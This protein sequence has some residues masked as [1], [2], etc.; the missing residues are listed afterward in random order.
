MLALDLVAAHPHALL[1]PAPLHQVVQPGDGEADES[2]HADQPHRGL[3][4]GADGRG[5]R[6]RA[7]GHDPLPGGTQD[8]PGDRPEHG[9]L[10]QRLGQAPRG[11][12]AEHPLDALAHV[13]VLELGLEPLGGDL[14]PALRGPAG[15]GHPRGG[16]Q[17]RRGGAGRPGRG[18]PEHL[19]RAVGLG[20]GDHLRQSRHQRLEGAAQPVD[21]HRGEEA[22]RE[23]R[24]P[25]GDVGRAGHLP[26]LHRLLAPLRGGLL[27]LLGLVLGH[28]SHPQ[29]GAGGAEALDDAVHDRAHRS[30]QEADRDG[31][32]AEGEQDLDREAHR[33]DV[34]GRHRPADQ[35]QRELGEEEHHDHR[36]R[37]L[38]RRGE[39]RADVR[40]DRLG[41]HA[42]A[43][44][45]QREHLVRRHEAAQQEQVAV[46]GEEQGDRDELVD[47]PEHAAADV[48][49]RVVQRG[50]GEPAGQVDQLT[51][52]LDGGEQQLGEEAER[53][54]DDHLE[55]GGQDHREQLRS[56]GLVD[57]PRTDRQG[58]RDGDGDLDQRRDGAAVER[59][60][61]DEPGRDP[62]R[63]QQHGQHLLD[64]HLQRHHGTAASVGQQLG[65]R[66]EQVVGEVHGL[67]EHPVAG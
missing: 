23:H 22:E 42:D 67:A 14:Q 36:R 8:D 19:D 11:V 38:Q 37:D 10:Q 60:R 45:V 5:Q 43:R 31:G 1:D 21:G 61:D 33:E 47:P 9:E 65:Q 32:E 57:Q 50:E 55:Q 20:P 62:D 64:R 44:G 7:A 28:R 35:P 34:Q 49:E 18:D 16:Q 53:E 59:R 4:P 25:R 40:E 58:D 30:G 26:V 39:E 27:G 2:R 17:H 24:Q 6:P 52:R 46:R 12:T 13:E 63:H 66:V 51:G 56:G 54:P 41:E 29:T 3:D 48:G 15:E